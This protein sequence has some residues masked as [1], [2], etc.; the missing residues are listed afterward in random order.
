MDEQ[1]SVRLIEAL[2]RVWTRI[3]IRHT[4]VP[5][6][7]LLAAPAPRTPHQSYLLPRL[8]RKANVV[9]NPALVSGVGER[10]LRI[11]HSTL[12][13][14]QMLCAAVDLNFAVE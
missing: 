4:D 13:T 3:R 5:P 8:C 2:S 6:V 10:Y 12:R 14:R 9:Q 11:F 7:V 1:R